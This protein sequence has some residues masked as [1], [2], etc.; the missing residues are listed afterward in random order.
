MTNKKSVFFSK[1]PKLDGSLKN[2][3]TPVAATVSATVATALT[4]LFMANSA[5][6]VTNSSTMNV[7]QNT[8]TANN[9]GVTV[10]MK[11]QASFGE[12]TYR[13]KNQKGQDVSYRGMNIDYGIEKAIN[14]NF[15]LRAD[16]S[17]AQHNTEFRGFFDDKSQTTGQ[18]DMVFTAIGTKRNERSLLFA[19]FGLGLSSGSTEVEKNSDINNASGGNST[20]L[21]VGAQ[22]DLV[23]AVI[24]GKIS[25]Q[26]WNEVVISSNFGEDNISEPATQI[27]NVFMERP[28]KD[29]LSVGGAIEY[30]NYDSANIKTKNKS[31]GQIYKGDISGTSEWQYSVYSVI[32]NKGFNVIPSVAMVLK[33]DGDLDDKSYFKLGLGAQLFF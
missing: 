24:G 10:E 17:Y 12:I 32:K 9:S 31:T 21:T 5:L 7:R 20:I 4:S 3:I 15:S 30:Y 22:M 6:A 13:P 23:S 28:V 26:K 27:Y 14:D 16:S 19:S 8:K 2:N 1:L 33:N 18:G 25:Y 29:S 11:S